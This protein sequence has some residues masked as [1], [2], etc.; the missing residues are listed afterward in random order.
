MIFSKQ[1]RERLGYAAMSVFVG[2]HT[3]AM[4]VAPAP[5]ESALVKFL[6]GL[7]QPY[8]ALFYLDNNWDFFAPNISGTFEFRYVVKDSTGIGHTFMPASKWSWFSPNS[9][10]FHAWYDAVIE[11]TDIYGDA[12]GRLLCQE[13]AELKPVSI[14]L[15]ALDEQEF[16][17]DDLLDGKRPLDPEFIEVR[18]V[19]TVKCPDQ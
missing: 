7:L 10:W 8:L 9:I 3:L 5:A 13:H 14:V 4:V 16:R 17:P 2:W 1:W 12:F 6:R 11:K 15:Q 19:K 18:R